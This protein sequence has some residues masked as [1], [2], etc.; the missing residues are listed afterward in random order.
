MTGC[1]NRTKKT[2][3][4]TEFI[5]GALLETERGQT[6]LPA[7]TIGNVDVSKMHELKVQSRSVV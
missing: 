2:L 3:D 1:G 6:K 5:K 4:L 7:R